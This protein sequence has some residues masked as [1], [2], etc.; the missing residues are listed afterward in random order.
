M[1]R[2]FRSR[3]RDKKGSL[4]FYPTGS[5]YPT[6]SLSRQ[7]NEESKRGRRWEGDTL[8]ALQWLGCGAR[9]RERLYGRS[10]T[11]TRRR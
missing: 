3:A 4:A 8:L 10:S 9:E 6:R 1:Q 5:T 2:R 11:H 7:R